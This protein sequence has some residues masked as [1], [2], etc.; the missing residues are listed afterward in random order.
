VRPVIG[1][2][3][4]AIGEVGRD[5]MVLGKS[6]KLERAGNGLQYQST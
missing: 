4:P 3:A 5:A 2:F 1:N 6:S